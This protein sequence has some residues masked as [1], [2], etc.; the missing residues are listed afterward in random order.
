MEHSGS[1]SGDL[2]PQ[3]PAG[4]AVS[5]GPYRDATTGA[6]ALGPFQEP[7]CSGFAGTARATSQGS[8]GWKLPW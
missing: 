7:D 2:A 8:R 6:G 5:E 4:A 1:E 3:C